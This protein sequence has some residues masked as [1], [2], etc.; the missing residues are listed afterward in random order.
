MF[1]F[2]RTNTLNVYN[3]FSLFSLDEVQTFHIKAKVF[4]LAFSPLSSYPIFHIPRFIPTQFF[5]TWFSLI[6]YSRFLLSFLFAYSFLLCL[7]FLLFTRK[8]LKHCS[9]TYELIRCFWIKRLIFWYAFSL[10]LRFVEP[11]WG[12]RRYPRTRSF[13]VKVLSFS[14][15]FLLRRLPP[16]WVEANSLN[17]KYY[18]N[19]CM[20]PFF[21]PFVCCNELL[22]YYVINSVF[23]FWLSMKLL[24]CEAN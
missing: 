4:K 5:F 17:D 8:S 13:D 18:F 19:P 14:A 12:W 22:V 7:G 23:S 10:A 9:A 11:K 15:G 1:L 2:I 6:F 3:Y 20:Y 24:L 16:N 21:P